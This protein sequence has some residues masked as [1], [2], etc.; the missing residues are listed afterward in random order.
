MGHSQAGKAENRA[1]ILEEAATLIREEGLS[2]VS[3]ARLMERVGLTVGGF[4]KHFASREELLEIVLE[5]ALT[6]GHA[7]AASATGGRQADFARV[8]RS[9]LS[10]T[11]RD[12]PGGG[13]AIAAL[14]GE[15]G[16]AGEGLREIMSTHIESFVSEMSAVLEDEDDSRAIAAVCAMVGA[17]SL[18][19][20]MADA[21]RSDQML[22]A[23]R[24][25]LI[26]EMD[27]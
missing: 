11:H 14:A 4:Y 23:V 19:R 25:Y 1:R 6:E 3:I 13:C 12:H 7:A 9:Y 17:L 20:V 2:G 10:R 8:V 24:D 26:A 27:A 18:S 16:R 15:T 21:Q 22:R 5:K